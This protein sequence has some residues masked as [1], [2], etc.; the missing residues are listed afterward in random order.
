MSWFKQL[1]QN[2]REK[3]QYYELQAQKYL[4]EQGLIAIERNYNCPYGELDVIMRD[5]DTLVF[6]EVKFRSSHI[7]GGALHAL[8]KQK[9]QRLKRTIYHY[10]AFKKL[11]NQALRIDFVAITGEVPQQLNWIKNVF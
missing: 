11:S 1:W 5:G 8:G 9:Q 7:K 2:S 4:E 10:L 3:G 6:V